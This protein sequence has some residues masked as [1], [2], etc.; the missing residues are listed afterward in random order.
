MYVKIIKKENKKQNYKKIFVFE[1]KNYF[2]IE[3]LVT[4]YL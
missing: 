3:M 2:Y 1:A 4:Q